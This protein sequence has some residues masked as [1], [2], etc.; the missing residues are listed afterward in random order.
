MLTIDRSQGAGNVY[1]SEAAEYDLCTQCYNLTHSGGY[2]PKRR[3]ESST[4]KMLQ[5]SPATVKDGVLTLKVLNAS[6]STRVH[7][8]TGRL[9]G[10][11]CLAQALTTALRSSQDGLAVQELSHYRSKYASERRLGDEHMYVLN[12]RDAKARPGNMLPRPSLLLQRKVVGDTTTVTQAAA[13]GSAYNRDM[14]EG[15]CASRS[16]APQGRRARSIASY[17]PS[18]DWLPSASGAALNLVPDASGLVTVPLASLSTDNFD[19]IFVTAVDRM[20]CVSRSLGSGS[21]APLYAR[22]RRLSDA[23]PQQQTLAEMRNVAV[24]QAGD[25][26][27]GVNDSSAD[28]TV[29]DTLQKAFDL[30]RTLVPGS[31]ADFDK[32]ALLPTRWGSMAEGEKR[33]AYSQLACHELNWFLKQKDPTFFADVVAPYLRN[34]LDKGVVDLALLGEDLTVLGPA[35][36]APEKLSCFELILVAQC[37]QTGLSM[38]QVVR[39]LEDSLA[40]NQPTAAEQA[41]LFDTALKT[42]A[43]DGGQAPPAEDRGSAGGGGGPGFGGGENSHAAPARPAP[44]RMKK[45]KAMNRMAAMPAMAAAPR[46]MAM[47]AMPEGDLLDL[48]DEMEQ[49]QLYTG[50]GRTKEMV[51]RGYWQEGPSSS[52]VQPG[53]FWLAYAAHLQDAS[54]GDPFVCDCWPSASHGFTEALLALGCLG[55]PAQGDVSVAYASSSVTVTA[56]GHPAVL[57]STQIA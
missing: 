34:K 51:E 30:Y 2:M 56:T 37:P 24:L 38:G 23:L 22:D 3:L 57:F 54:P 39:F 15:L 33:A 4:V 10:D 14:E 41:R 36:L 11:E 9:L 50:P 28:F 5:L 7:V 25:S 47:C 40:A 43:L 49:E 32:F 45:K 16:A 18:I 19:R 13:L 8:F 53:P 17:S 20:Q 44:Q 48:R 12:R 26:W 42:S 6:P 35:L 31:A 21:A 55:L 1:H 46:A 52:L 29:Y 27:T